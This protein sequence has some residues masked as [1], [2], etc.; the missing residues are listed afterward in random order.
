MET[1]IRGLNIAGKYIIIK[2]EVLAVPYREMKYRVWK[3]LS[4]FGCSPESYGR[5]VFC[6]AVVDGESTRF[7]RSDVERLAT[8]EEVKAV[9]AM[10]IHREKV[11]QIEI[12]TKG[13]GFKDN[14]EA[15]YEYITKQIRDKMTEAYVGILWSLMDINGNKVGSMRIMYAEQENND[16]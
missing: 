16:D 15:E 1:D 8:P 11:I 10:K 9:E 6:K 14:P 13:A 4:G 12:R 7:N 3:A 2:E 5:A